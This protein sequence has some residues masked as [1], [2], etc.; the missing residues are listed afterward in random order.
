MSPD[1]LLGY[2]LAYEITM[3]W[4][5][6]RRCRDEVSNDA[7]DEKEDTKQRSH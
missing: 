5:T 4:E 3:L 2:H 6:Y 1:E 7:A